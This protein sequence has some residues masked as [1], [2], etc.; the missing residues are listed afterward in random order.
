M[1][2]E[3]EFIE[4]RERIEEVLVNGNLGFLGMSAD[5]T[6]YTI[7]ITYGYDNGRILFHCARFGSKL[8]FLRANPA[9]C[10]TT[11]TQFGP[12][13]RH[14][15][16]AVCRAHS[17]SV[18]CRGSARIIEDE[19]ERCRVLNAFN[20]CILADAREIRV[21]EVANCYAVEITLSEMTARVE[22]DSRCTHYRY[23]FER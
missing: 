2:K 5:S 21:D 9:V 14:P 12:V 20:R 15:Q 3:K 23:A 10:F 17:D 18:V 6:P 11:A 1:S 22:R 4:S 19:E 16:G 13:V 7:P 8:E